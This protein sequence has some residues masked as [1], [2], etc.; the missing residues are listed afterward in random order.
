MERDAHDNK[1]EEATRE[2][3]RQG[4]SREV[5]QSELWQGVQLDLVVFVLH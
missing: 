3:E 5:Y 1:E 2:K 4:V